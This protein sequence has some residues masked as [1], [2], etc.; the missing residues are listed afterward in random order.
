M[1]RLTEAVQG[2]PAALRAGQAPGRRAKLRNSEWAHGF[3][4]RPRFEQV[5]G[6]LERNEPLLDQPGRKAQHCRRRAG[7]SGPHRR[8]GRGTPSRAG[9]PLSAA[10]GRSHLESVAS[11]DAA[12]FFLLSKKIQNGH[13]LERREQLRPVLKAARKT[14]FSEF[15]VFSAFCTKN[16]VVTKTG[17][18][19]KTFSGLKNL[20]VLQGFGTKNPNELGWYKLPFLTTPGGARR[21][22]L[23]LRAACAYALLRNS[24]SETWGSFARQQQPLPSLCYL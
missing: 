5:V 10:P 15:A 16:G 1:S 14:H 21:G 13:I 17:N 6:Y 3:N 19:G 8:R 11:S 7:G 24:F 23:R 22:F 12:A 2:T 18:I 9:L 20:A 4:Q